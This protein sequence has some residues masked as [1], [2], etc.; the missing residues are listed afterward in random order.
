MR[1]KH[2]HQLNIIDCGPACLRM[3]AQHYGRL[4]TLDTL[5]ERSFV[6]RE[7]VS[8]LGLSDAAESIGL[9]SSGVKT[10]LDKLTETAPL[11]CVLHWNQ[12]HFVVLYGIKKRR[13]RTIYQIADPAAQKVSY[14]REELAKCWESSSSSNGKRLGTAL[15]LEPSPEF[16]KNS[17]HIF[18]ITT[19]ELGRTTLRGSKI[20][21]Y[22][23]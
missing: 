19:A 18:H 15:L 21:Q 3:I 8:M 9:R 13:G 4:Y 11:P 16:Y 20:N 22:A 14:S 7:G 17:H 23:E 6:T 5:R 12:N 1:F 2:F 10:S